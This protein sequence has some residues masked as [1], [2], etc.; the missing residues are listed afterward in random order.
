MIQV[1]LQR[2]NIVPSTETVDGVSMT[3]VVESKIGIAQLLHNSLEVLIE[4]LVVREILP[5]STI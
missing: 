4:H 2:F 3:K 5:L 1:L